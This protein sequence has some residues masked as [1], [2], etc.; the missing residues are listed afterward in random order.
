MDWPLDE[1]SSDVHKICEE[2]TFDKMVDQRQRDETFNFKDEEKE[3][4]SKH[5]SLTP[6]AIKKNTHVFSNYIF[7][8]IYYNAQTSQQLYL[9]PNYCLPHKIE[10]PDHVHLPVFYS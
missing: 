9:L 3:H 1:R 10:I 2:T 7:F 6:A 8:I 4:S 5:N